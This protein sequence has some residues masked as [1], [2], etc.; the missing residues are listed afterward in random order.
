MTTD[1]PKD[2]I[3]A[4]FIRRALLLVVAGIEADYPFL[5]PTKR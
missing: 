4:D 5:K 1:K 2:A 3:L